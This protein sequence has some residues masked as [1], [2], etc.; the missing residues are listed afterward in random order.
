MVQANSRAPAG[1][2]LGLA[3]AVALSAPLLTRARV[4]VL[5]GLAARRILPLAVDEQLHESKGQIQSSQR[6]RKLGIWAGAG[7]APP[8]GLLLQTG[9]AACLGSELLEH[10]VCTIDVAVRRV[11]KSGGSSLLCASMLAADPVP[12]MR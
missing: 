6:G 2:R 5:K 11:G 9:P 10:I 7:G 4:E 8:A 1:G 12:S 3:V